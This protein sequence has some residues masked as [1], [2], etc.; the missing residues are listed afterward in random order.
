LVTHQ[1]TLALDPAPIETIAKEPASPPLD[2]KAFRHLAQGKYHPH[3]I[4]YLYNINKTTSKEPHF[5]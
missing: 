5:G 1:N 2:S 4:S 3:K